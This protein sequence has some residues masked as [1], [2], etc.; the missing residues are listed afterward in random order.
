MLYLFLGGNL[1]NEDIKNLKKWAIDPSLTEHKQKYLTK[2]GIK[3]LTTLGERFK[4]YL[5]ELFQADSDKY[6]VSYR[7]T[8]SN[9]SPIFF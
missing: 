8:L 7:N 1:C 4:N 2:Q 6:I 5:P 3:D 9:Y